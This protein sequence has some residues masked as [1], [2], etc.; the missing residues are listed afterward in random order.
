MFSL[1]AKFRDGLKKTAVSL[2]RAISG[3]ATWTPDDFARL[4]KSLIEADLGVASAQ[5]VVKDIR[6]RYELGEIRSDEDIRSV[7]ASSLAAIVSANARPLRRNPDGPTVV[8]FLGVNG[9]GKT[10]S[11]GK[12]AARLRD[13]G[14]KVML[15]A[16]DTFRAAAVEQLK[17]WAE[18]TDS[19]IVS[20][21]PNADAAAVAYDAVQSAVAR[22]ADYLLIDTAGRQQNSKALMAELA[23]VVRIIGKVLPGAPHETIVVIDASHGTNSIGQAREFVGV[24]GATA[25]I[26]TKMDGTGKGGAVCAIQKEFG[27]PIL[28]VGFGE[29]KDDLL[30]FDAESYANAIFQAPED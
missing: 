5:A 24:S 22:K 7:A 29:G 2:G 6:H 18:R 20:G 26:L 3:N 19:A 30:P 16:C 9:S 25:A 21:K 28:F 12:L 13:E 17:L 10:T 14:A 15:A 1:F 4:E 23:K 8:L 27:L 11:I